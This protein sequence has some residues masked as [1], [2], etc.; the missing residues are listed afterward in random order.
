MKLF[1]R[2]IV[3]TVLASIALVT[4]ALIAL[5]G[6]ILSVNQLDDLGKG[7]YGLGSAASVVLLSLPKQVYSFF[8]VA[9]LLGCLLGLGLLANN[10]ELLVM[11]AAG[12]SIARVS[13][14]VCKAAFIL[15][16]LVTVLSEVVMPKGLAAA[17]YKK[18]QAINLEQPLF[19]A[20]NVWIRAKHDFLLIGRVLPD[21]QLEQVLQFHFDASNHLTL[22]RRLAKAHWHAGV[23][24]ATGVHETHI[25][26]NNTRVVERQS[27]IWN[28]D[29]NPQILQTSQ[30][31]PDEM[32]VASLYRILHTH[33]IEQSA[34]LRYELVY[35]QRLIQPFTTVVM[36][37]LAIPFVFGPLRS[38]TM[39]AKLLIGVSVGFG[40]HLINRFFAPLSQVLH[41]PPL[42]AAL[43]PTAIFALLSFYMM[44]QVYR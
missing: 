13:W 15:I 32:D 31:D 1:E 10:R 22:T 41:W 35:W 19:G 11:R 25:H 34:L 23:W 14:A 5:N 4:V 29:I 44:R 16:L 37:L 2:Y 8:P 26:L 36:M 9:S 33:G 39:G 40:F 12:I 7:S 18:S 28:V 3:K 24:Q 38:S 43:C 20:R 17:R 6:F 27:I 42:L 30:L 21:N